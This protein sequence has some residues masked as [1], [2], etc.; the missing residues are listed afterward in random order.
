MAAGRDG[1]E[2]PVTV[3]LR[4][5]S[6]GD[7]SVEEV[8]FRA[9]YGELEGIARRLMRSERDDHTLR[10]TAL[11]SEAY[12]R[13]RKAGLEYRDRRHFLSVAARV[14]RRYLVD[15]ARARARLKRGGG[16]ERV[17]LEAGLLPAPSAPLDILVFDRAL[18]RL[19]AHDP[20]KAEFV[21]L[22][23]LAG[24]RNE[25]IAELAGVSPRTV[26]RDLAFARAFLRAEIEAAAP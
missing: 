5:W 19:E 21:E 26:K 23:H 25:E 24:L 1:G 3:L 10:P 9:I 15:H 7:R 20:R 14:M 17:T 22:R 4:R 12:L 13:L 16:G 2:V 11:V 18:Q 8:L 6:A